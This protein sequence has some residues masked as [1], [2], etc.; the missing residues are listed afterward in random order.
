MIE[1]YVSFIVF[2]VVMT[3]TPGMGNLSMMSLGQNAGFRA[4]MP[5]LC[6]ATVGFGVLGSAVGLGLGELVRGSEWAGQ[7]LRWG[8]AAYILYLAVK[9]LRMRPGAAGPVRSLG[10]GEG[11]FLHP[12]NPKS[13]A[14]FVAGFGMLYDPA[15]SMAFQL[16]IFMI[17][18]LFFQVSFHSLWGAAGTSL[19]RFLGR[20]K[21][22][23]GIN[24]L[25][26]GCMVGATLY[27]LVR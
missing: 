17:T 16:L 7:V 10:F 23:R 19:Q 14:M 5:F 6:G 13:W 15:Q 20:G 18:F 11:L 26:V 21:M 9:L 25:L 27:A 12:L 4:A 24:V 2:V 22:L 3:G 1:K 8:G